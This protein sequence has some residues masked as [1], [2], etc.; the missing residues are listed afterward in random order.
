MKI[1]KW[2]LSPGGRVGQETY[3]QKLQE[4]MDYIERLKKDEDVAEVIVGE[5]EITIKINE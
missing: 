4:G 1:V 2:R 3:E 5:K